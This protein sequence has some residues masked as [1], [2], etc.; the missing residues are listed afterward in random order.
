MRA[1]KAD[2]K[3]GRPVNERPKN[4]VGT[5]ELAKHRAILAGPG[6]PALSITPLGIML[7][8]ELIDL[9][10]YSA[11]EAYRRLYGSATGRARAVGLDPGIGGGDEQAL[12][13][14]T[15]QYRALTGRLKRLGTP[16]LREVVNTCVFQERPVWLMLYLHNPHKDSWRVH[17]HH[18]DCINLFAGLEELAR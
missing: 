13:R 14:I 3:R 9:E 11:G 4:D 6:D 7:A 5:A 16:V 18:I 10:W 15:D 17:R 8:R 1:V 2:N 12:E